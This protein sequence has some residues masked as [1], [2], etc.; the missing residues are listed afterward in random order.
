MKRLLA[1]VLLLAGVLAGCGAT[2]TVTT[3]STTTSTAS[4]TT[5]APVSRTAPAIQCPPGNITLGCVL[6]K[7]PPPTR[8]FSLVP[9][10][11]YGVDFGWSGVSASGAR[12]IGAKFGASYFS[13]DPSKNWT[14]SSVDAYHAA[15]LATVGVWETAA[16]RA[17]DGRAAGVADAVAARSEAVAVGNTTAGIDFAVDCDCA[18]SSILAYFQ[19]V[20]SVLGDRGNAYGGY[21]QVLYLYQHHMVG[22]MNWQ[23]YAW[24]GGRWLP[25]SIAPL[26]QYLNGN[27]F[28]NDRA[29]AANY[30]QWPAPSVKPA[31]RWP[32]APN[33][34]RHFGHR[35]HAR[36]HNTLST[37]RARGCR[38]PLRRLI[39]KSTHRHEVLLQQRIVAVATN[40]GRR[41]HPAWGRDHLGVRYQ[42]FARDLKHRR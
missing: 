9:G 15:G 39:C 42:Y 1:L 28:D 6:A 33:V 31:D 8:L 22:H 4:A 38:Y 3:T 36:E 27:A 18:G 13:H 7:Q 5:L 41:K 40:H 10:Q 2:K 37:W 17:E 25:A 20:H 12:A 30:G 11:Q 32:D 14:H 35:D 26:E 23:T 19:G 16:T 29:I 34:V 24:S 21:S